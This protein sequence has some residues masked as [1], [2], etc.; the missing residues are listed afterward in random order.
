M[1]YMINMCLEPPSQTHM[2]WHYQSYSF[3]LPIHPP[4]SQLLKT[5]LIVALDR[6]KML[7]K[8]IGGVSGG[9]PSSH[10]ESVERF[11]L[12]PSP[13]EE[14]WTKNINCFSFPITEFFQHFQFSFCI[15]VCV[16]VHLRIWHYKWHYF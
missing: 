13:N 2:D 16:W 15:S 7:K 4:L 12:F 5:N 1:V 14:S 11:A 9:D 10:R 8:R 3:N 6:Y